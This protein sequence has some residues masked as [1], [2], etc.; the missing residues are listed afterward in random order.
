MPLILGEIIAVGAGA[1]IGAWTRWGLTWWLNDHY[2]KFPLGTL[3]CNLIGGLGVGIALAYFLAHHDLP[4]HYRLFV[5][6]G[7]LGGLTTVST[8]SSEVSMLLLRGDYLTGLALSAS[9]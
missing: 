8:F 2:P 4:P 1:A 3:A 7:L 9:R 6:T 5:I